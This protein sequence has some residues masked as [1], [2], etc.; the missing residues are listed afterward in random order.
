MENAH[1]VRPRRT[2]VIGLI[3]PV[4]FESFDKIGFLIL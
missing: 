3:A 4:F 1:E 2:I